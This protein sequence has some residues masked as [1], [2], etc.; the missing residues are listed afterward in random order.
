MTLLSKDKVPDTVWLQVIL[1]SSSDSQRRVNLG[2][3]P[4]A[5]MMESNEVPQTL[6]YKVPA[7]GLLSEFDGFILR[8]VLKE[9]RLDIVPRIRIQKFVFQP[10]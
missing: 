9:P 3:A 4:I 6:T 8:F 2:T 10:R 5:L 1:T 7:S